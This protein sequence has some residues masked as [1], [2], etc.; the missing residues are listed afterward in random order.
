MRIAYSCAGEGLGHSVRTSVIGPRRRPAQARIFRSRAGQGLSRVEDGKRRFEDIPHFAFEKRGEKVL[1]LATVF[2]A[3]PS[4][5]RFSYDIVRYA[6]RLRELKI[7]AV[8][9]DFEPI[10]PRAA[11]ALGIPVFQLNHPGIVQRVARLHPFA[12]LNSFASRILEGPWH[13]RA[14]I[15]FY[16]GDVGPIIRREIF[17]YPLSDEGFVLLNLK[18][19]YRPAA[20]DLGSGWSRLQAVPEPE[21]G[22]REGPGRM[23]LRRLIGRSPDNRR[24]ARAQQ[25]DSGGPAAGSM[26]T[27]PEREDGRRDRERH[28]DE[29][30]A[31]RKRSASLPRWAG[32]ISGERPIE[33]IRRLGQQ[34]EDSAPDR[35]LPR[36]LLRA[37]T[38]M[39]GP[40]RR[41]SAIGSGENQ[42]STTRRL[43]IEAA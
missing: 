1:V 32:G 33:P 11:R 42:L 35:K 39:D 20:A 27:M 37:E 15:S 12:W 21:R 17:R 36:A 2:R 3:L 6:K 14:H 13:E 5:A 41:E 4:I 8:I 43:L 18:A 23:L 22:L 30:Q 24:V 31:L 34:H 9:S 10:S 19:C 40:Q 16:G 38:G 7:D 28:V 25:A 29:P 26:G